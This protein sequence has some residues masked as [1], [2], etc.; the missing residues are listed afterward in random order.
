MKMPRCS[1][2]ES[3]K[4]GTLFCRNSVMFQLDRGNAEKDKIEQTQITALWSATK[5]E[6]RETRRAVTP[7]GG[8]VLFSEFLRRVG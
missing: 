6:L 2:P 4:Q 5:V 3:R 1:E 7:F 8:L